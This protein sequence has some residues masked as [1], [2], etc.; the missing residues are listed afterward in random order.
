MRVALG[1]DARV[2]VAENL[3][4]HCHPPL[5]SPSVYRAV[6]SSGQPG[7]PFPRE[8]SAFLLRRLPPRRRSTP[9][10]ALGSGGCGA[11]D[12][13][14]EE[15]DVEASTAPRQLRSWGSP[16]ILVDGTDVAGA[17]FPMGLSCRLYPGGTSGIPPRE[18]TESR[19][20]Q[21][22]ANP[23]ASR[24][25][26]GGRP[27]YQPVAPPWTSLR[28]RVSRGQSG[29]GLWLRG[30]QFGLVGRRMFRW[31]TLLTRRTGPRHA[32]RLV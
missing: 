26:R 13:M 20:R 15:I 11:G 6:A 27:Q 29:R 5:A 1:R 2:C 17:D 21:A 14:V 22:I 30:Y 32:C 18:L 8:G 25:S 23:L 7:Y 4:H 16:R 9:R 28:L 3:L 24:E 10:L 19:S 12:L 31:V